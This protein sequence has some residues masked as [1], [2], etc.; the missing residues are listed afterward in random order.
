MRAAGRELHQRALETEK[1]VDRCIAETRGH[2]LCCHRKKADPCLG[3]K[4][5]FQ[6]SSPRRTARS[7]E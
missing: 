3:I 6:Q 2:L 5:G 1:L 7:I 4:I